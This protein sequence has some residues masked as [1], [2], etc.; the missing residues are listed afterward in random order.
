MRAN[1][2]GYSSDLQKSVITVKEVKNEIENVQEKHTELGATGPQGQNG[3]TGPAGQNGTRGPIGP[4]GMPGPVGPIGPI[5]PEGPQGPMGPTGPQGEVGPV[6]PKGNIGPRILQKSLLFYNRHKI[7]QNLTPSVVFPY[8]GYNFHLN[9]IIVYAN[10]QSKCFFKLC[11]PE[12]KVVLCEI[13]FP[14]SGLTVFELNKFENIPLS[15]TALEL[16]CCSLQD[17]EKDSEFI[18][19]EINM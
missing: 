19:A 10:L 11:V 12:T 4:V 5:G 1:I 2:P 16:S 9:S 18:C 13:E 3:H 17:S 8:D 6:G 14:D 15:L 7:L